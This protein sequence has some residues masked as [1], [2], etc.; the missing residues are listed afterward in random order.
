MSEIPEHQFARLLE[1]LW[2]IHQRCDDIL[3]VLP[4]HIHPSYE[5]VMREE[6]RKLA[7][8]KVEEII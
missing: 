4:Q 3:S 2:A 6:A 8:N 7:K 5:D 1:V